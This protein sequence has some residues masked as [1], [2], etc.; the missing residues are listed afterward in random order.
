M[1]FNRP[2]NSRDDK[3]GRSSN[4]AP[5]AGDRPKRSPSSRG[6]STPGSDQAKSS[7][8]SKKY[9][10]EGPGEKRSFSSPGKS[11]YDKPASSFSGGPGEKKAF[12]G[13]SRPAEG[14]QMV[15][16][17]AKKGHLPQKAGHI[18]AEL[19]IT[20][21]D[22]EK[23]LVAKE[24]ATRNLL[25][26]AV[27]RR[28]VHLML[29][30][31]PK[32]ALAAKELAIKNLLHRAANRQQVHLTLM[33]NPK[34]VLAVIKNSATGQLQVPGLKEPVAINRMTLINHIAQNHVTIK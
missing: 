34:E 18:Q 27:N 11:S 16:H 7:R 33:I 15:N 12:T 9:N 28:Q 32:E 13:K 22:Q 20:T 19:Q 2:G 31:D 29:T 26:R 1:A 8:P 21:Q 23:A 17:Q 6:N 14:H 10:S 5:K 30:T 3:S 25:H 4:R 24:Q